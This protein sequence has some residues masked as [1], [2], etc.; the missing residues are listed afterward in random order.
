MQVHDV[1]VSNES[2]T[3]YTRDSGHPGYESVAAQHTAGRRT[4]ERNTITLDSFFAQ[5]GLQRAQLVSID[6]EGWDGL[7][8][9]G[10]ERVLTERRVDVV[11]FEYMRAW[12][13]VLGER[14][15]QAT[16]GY[17]ESKGYPCFWQGNRGALAQASGKCWQ[18]EFH[19][20]IS[21]RW[22]NLVCSH[23]E[24]VLQVFRRLR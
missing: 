9:H 2:G 15:L 5:R 6:T 1:A 14:S 10:M 3:V 11:E 4:I 8:L 23:R 17:M 16:L 21:H 24:D 13:R 12:K 22:S 18:E 20:R 7:V 19:T